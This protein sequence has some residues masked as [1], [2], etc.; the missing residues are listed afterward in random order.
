[1]E[2]ERSIEPGRPARSLLYHA[3]AS[4]SVVTGARGEE[5]A[6]FPTLA[7]INAVENF[8]FG[9]QPP[10]LAEL[11]VRFPRAPMAVV[12]FASEYRPGPETVHRR[13]ADLCL[14]RTGVARVGT[15]EPL[16][17][18]AARGFLPFVD[19]DDRAIRVL[20]AQYA[21]YV[22]VQLRGREELFGPMNFD[23]RRQFSIEPELGDENRLFWV[24]LHKLFAGEECVRGYDLTGTLET[25][26]S[27]E[28]IRRVHLG[29][30]QRGYETGWG[31]PHIDRPPF[32]FADG[33]AEFS[34][35]PDSGEGVLTPVVHEKLVEPAEY[36]GS[37]LSFLVPSEP[38]NEWSPSL[39]IKSSENGF[40]RAPSTCTHA[41]R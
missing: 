7:E 35:D 27:N 4:P 36:Q 38:R 29:L 37:P 41:M 26:H 15:A 5:L 21:P 13:H 25:H 23:L 12:V 14:S 11:A 19:G 3:L 16:Y 9:V 2:G 17:D 31:K 22:A 39:L 34:Q 24:P 28:K 6:A 10:S 20:P 33:I 1:M 30:R 32:V 18:A 8:V 40:R